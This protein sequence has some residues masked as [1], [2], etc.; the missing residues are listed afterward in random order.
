MNAATERMFGYT[1]AE[2]IGQNVKMLMPSPYH[3]E[4][5]GYLDRYAEDGRKANHRHRPGGHGPAAKTARTFPVGPG[6]QRGGAVSSS[7][8]AF[9]ATSPGARNWRREVV[10]IASLEQRRSARTCTTAWARS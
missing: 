3:E 4:H 5:D 7:S 2:M 8:R 1:A 6:C 9:S 10:E